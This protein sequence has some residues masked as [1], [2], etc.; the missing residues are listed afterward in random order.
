M[1][2]ILEIT[3]HLPQNGAYVKY[4]HLP[5]E[6]GMVTLSIDKLRKWRISL[7]LGVCKWK[8]I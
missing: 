3:K 7:L 5:C 4:P 8:C 1:S 6:S 2:E